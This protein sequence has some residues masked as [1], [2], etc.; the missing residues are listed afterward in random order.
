MN[1]YHQEKSLYYELL[2]LLSPVQKEAE[3]LPIKHKCWHI[4]ASQTKPS[5]A[6]YLE[7]STREEEP[8]RRLCTGRFLL[9]FLKHSLKYKC[10]KKYLRR[11]TL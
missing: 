7:H 9:Q 5:T 2:S 10:M 11:P 3:E 4:L 6:S 8:Q 1:K